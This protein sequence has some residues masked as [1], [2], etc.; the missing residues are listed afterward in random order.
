M[1]FSEKKITIDCLKI[2]LQVINAAVAV[3]VRKHNQLNPG[4]KAGFIDSF[5]M[6]AMWKGKSPRLKVLFYIMNIQYIS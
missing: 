6:S 3:M 5:A 2:S 4:E 1:Y